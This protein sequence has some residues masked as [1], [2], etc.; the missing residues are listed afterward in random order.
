[1][2]FEKISL[3]EGLSNS[4][5]SSINQDS[6]GLLWITTQ[7]GLN[8]FDGYRFKVYKN[9]DHNKFSIPENSV[10][11]TYEDSKKNLWIGGD[12]FSLSVFNLERNEMMRIQLSNDNN[13]FH[14]SGIFEDT[15]ENIWVSTFGN[16][17]YKIKNFK[18]ISH[19]T[20]KQNSSDF[21]NCNDIYCMKYDRDSERIYIGT[22]TGGLNIMDLKNY[23]FTHHKF[24]I[25]NPNSISDNRIKHIFKDSRNNLW[26]STHQKG[27]NKF[28]EESTEFC[29]YLHDSENENS[30]SENVL[31]DICED[32]NGI[33]WIASRNQGLN[34]FDTQS[35]TFTHYK[36]DKLNASTLSCN[37]ICSLFIDR[38]N[39]LWIGTWGEGLCKTDLNQ[40]KFSI[41]SEKLINSNNVKFDKITSICV[42]SKKSI[43]LGTYGIGIYK[44]EPEIYSDFRK[45]DH[46]EKKSVYNVY[47]DNNNTLWF[48]SELLGLCSYNLEF[49]LFEIHNCE[50]YNLKE[51]R[52]FP[53]IQD[54]LY[55]NILWVGTE[56]HGLLLFD[57]YK[58]K[59]IYNK[60][61]FL[62][63]KTI[64]S[65]YRDNQGLLWIGTNGTGVFI[66]DSK[67][68][69][70]KNSRLS[71]AA[72]KLNNDKVWCITEDSL[73]NI[74]FGTD[75][76]LCKICRV[77]GKLKR[78]KQI[79]GISND[80]VFGILKDESNNLW[81]STN[82]GISKFDIMQEK[83][84]NYYHHDGLSGNEF[85]AFSFYK[86]E[87]GVMYFGGMNGVTFFNPKEI[88]DNEFI[89]KIV[90]T[91]F[92]I[93][94]K[95]VNG[96][97]E[98]PY[99][100]KNISFADEI[101]LTYRESVFS[102]KFASLIYNN[103]QK[104]QYAYKMDGFDKDWTYC[105]TRRRVTYTNLDPGNY[106][107]R[108]KGSNND[109]KWNEEGTSV[110]INIT[111][112]Y[113]KTWWFKSLGI[114]GAIA[115]TGLT[116]KQRLNKIEKEKIKQEEF[117][118]KLIESQESERKR[119]A[120]EL[121]DTIAHE[122]LISKN[123]A[124]LA[125]KHKDNINK[126]EEALKDISELAS[127]TINDVR[128][129]SYNLHPHQLERL[130]IKKTLL[131][132]IYDAD[133]STNITFHSDIDEIDNLLSKESEI[134]LFRVIQEIISNIIK[135]SNATIAKF[136]IKIL[137][138]N[139]FVIISD[140]GK[141]FDVSSKYIPDSKEGIGLNGISERIKFMGQYK[142]ESEIG[143]GT[144]YKI[145]IP[146][147]T[148]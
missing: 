114:L 67:N 53:L 79:D 32:K 127:V 72:E 139:I 26:I 81:L 61:E 84:Y 123:K 78:Y 24:N 17:F 65:I 37:S 45:F 129:I 99:L 47:Q 30:I 38:S 117:S 86:D 90:I 131:S 14:I 19:Y 128:S 143:K 3:N 68:E 15:Q 66:F 148:N 33:L 122:I 130:G 36:F 132:I 1:M 115:A 113:W 34:R 52:I 94:N 8:S 2:R 85:N 59:F 125:L 16:G 108:V 4:I 112:P 101:N 105:G 64:Y 7:D 60:K 31:T 116:Y 83:F 23:K 6:V 135:H 133:K 88:K 29:R 141:G 69:L 10:Q 98:D 104:N 73:N 92:E 54:I 9:N 35:N 100:R 103:P 44:S 18:V 124:A 119:I 46:I 22:W 43:W 75:S 49:D 56:K 51:I 97:L 107:F 55:D 20:S 28:Y 76:G 126:M 41:L 137:S 39:V 87:N 93:F 120:H 136:N 140:N 42:D 27:L 96:T 121:H 138:N 144:V 12:K 50:K 80:T 91:D 145:K 57:I 71:K 142:I 63:D 58:K 13:N 118:R 40:K 134:N 95:P 74:W 48:S 25:N 70:I 89:P 146:I 109:G 110:K 147:K 21:I 5:V 82:N 11:L 102:F 106:T 62:N 77:T 111:P